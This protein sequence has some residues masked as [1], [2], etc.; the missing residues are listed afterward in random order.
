MRGKCPISP[1]Q[2]AD[3][4]QHPVTEAFHRHLEDYCRLM[5]DNLTEVW[6]SGQLVSEMTQRDY[7]SVI[8]ALNNVRTLEWEH[9]ASRYP[10][11]AAEMQASEVTE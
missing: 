2:W 8:T 1:E 6:A 7:Q 9:I 3:W 10:D 11:T 4:Q 5:A